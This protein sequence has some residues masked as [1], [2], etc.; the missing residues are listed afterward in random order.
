MMWGNLKL[1]GRRFSG[2]KFE[3]CAQDIRE[4]LSLSFHPD[5]PL[6]SL[7]SKLALIYGT[8]DLNQVNG[9][10]NN[11]GHLPY[12]LEKA[13]LTTENSIV[14]PIDLGLSRQLQPNQIAASP[15]IHDYL[16]EL[17]LSILDVS[18]AQVVLVSGDLAK[19]HVTRRP[20]SGLISS[21]DTEA[22]RSTYRLLVGCVT[23]F[24]PK[25][26]HWCARFGESHLSSR[27]IT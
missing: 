17:T 6:G 14:W 24:N 9:D 19:R 21:P 23:K 20:S 10:E 2:E 4:E 27:V 26:L 7:S 5:T 18:D 11:R 1:R 13:G 3:R 15:Q 22:S 8:P 25:G 12:Q 16:S